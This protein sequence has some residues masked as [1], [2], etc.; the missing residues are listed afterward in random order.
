MK[1]WWAFFLCLAILLSASG[2]GGEPVAL[3]VAEEICRALSL[4]AGIT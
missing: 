4:P 3:D 1:R 2:C